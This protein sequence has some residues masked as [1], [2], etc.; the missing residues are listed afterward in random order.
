[1]DALEPDTP[2]KMNKP[3]IC[4]VRLKGV[5][6]ELNHGWTRMNTDVTEES[7]ENKRATE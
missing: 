3:Q 2:K 7:E 6:P 4:T 5:K 1:V